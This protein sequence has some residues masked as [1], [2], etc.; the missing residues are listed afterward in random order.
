MSEMSRF[1]Q[2][3]TAKL[4]G[5]EYSGQPLS[6]VEELLMGLGSVSGG[7]SYGSI[8]EGGENDFKD[9]DISDIM[10]VISSEND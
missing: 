7:G 3:L 4:E 5:K 10:N 2:I 9:S 6:R 8:S 1:E